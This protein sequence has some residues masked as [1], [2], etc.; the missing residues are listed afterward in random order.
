MEQQ[1]FI[2]LFERYKQGILTSEEQNEFFMAVENTNDA[3]VLQAIATM[4]DASAGYPVFEEKSLTDA[5]FNRIINIDKTL[6]EEA[7]DN[8]NKKPLVRL[9]IN[10]R[11][12]VAAA[13]VLLI[14]AVVAYLW[15]AKNAQPGKTV[16]NSNQQLSNDALAGHNGAVLTLGNGEQVMLDS[17]GNGVITKQGKTTVLN[18]NGQ[19]VYDATAVKGDVLFNTMTTP[20]GRQ[21]QLQL[22]DGSKVW[23]NAASSITY[24]T[25]FTGKERSVILT[26]EAYFEVAKDK[27][28]PFRVNVNNQS[29]VEVL[30]THFNINS[31][32]D[33]GKIKT[34]LLEGSVKVISYEGKVVIKPGQQAQ[35]SSA[36][37][38]GN[39]KGIA[40]NT[41]VDLEMVMAW[42][43]GSFQFDRTPLSQVLNQ[44]SRWYDVQVVYEH[45][46]PD[47]R[48]SGEMK[49]D[50]R[51]AQ[52]LKGFGKIGVNF[53]IE[54]KKLIVLL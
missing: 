19:L 40:V 18:R 46:V 38:P 28:K 9:L 37:Q 42:K 7:T 35:V 39:K 1:R 12:W 33:D 45:G 53:R 11:W 26:G 24:P 47:I 3:A 54:G 13:S 20:K 6:A 49:R 48:L 29:Q 4:A 22:P 41:N 15:S 51:L 10:S 44:L 36:P 31:Y 30:G 5:A 32:G 50:L 27:S 25:A 17:L 43:N 16:V 14:L 23:L 2:Y 52:V 21:Y 8:K 34:T